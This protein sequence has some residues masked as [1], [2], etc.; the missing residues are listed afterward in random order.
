MIVFPLD[1]QAYWLGFSLV[2]GIGSK[3]ILSLLSQFDSLKAAWHASDSELHKAG[4]GEK[5]MTGFIKLRQQLDL[6]AQM[7]RIKDVGAWLL[8]YTDARYPKLLRQLD[9][10][11]AVLYVRGTLQ[12]QDA[13]ALGIV[14]TRKASRYG[15]DA[16]FQLSRDL[17]YQ[18]VTI[19]SGMAQGVDAAAHRGAIQAGGR[20]IA[21]MGCGVDIIYPQEHKELAAQIV[22]HGAIISEFNMGTNPIGA[23]FPRRNRLISGMSL[24]VLVTE[25]PE[26]SGSL[27]TASFAAE[28]GREVFALPH[29]IYNKQGSGTNRLIQDGAK[30]ITDITDILNELNIAYQTVETRTRTEQIAPSNETERLILQHLAVD[31][32]HIDDLTR[33]CGLSIAE[34]TSTLTILELKGLAQ[35]VGHMQYSRMLT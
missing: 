15:Y 4:L 30:L 35:M 6:A 11:P 33:L 26:K 3:R 23:N 32:I 5:A 10:P 12:P 18:G 19:I 28:Q 24:G 8:I 1:E 21:V 17:A 22:Q 14:G 34:V 9:D 13:H 16:T 27:I 7:K 29:N 2:P 20:T 25:A 31:P